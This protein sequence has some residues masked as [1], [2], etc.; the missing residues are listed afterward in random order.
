MSE[1]KA[2]NLGDLEVEGL[3]SVFIGL[4]SEKALGYLGLPEKEET[5]KDMKR[6]S[7]AINSILSLIDQIGPLIP[8]EAVDQYRSLLSELQIEYVRQMHSD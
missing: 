6:A 3:L 8:E 4:L 2:V 5:V 1:P 7:V